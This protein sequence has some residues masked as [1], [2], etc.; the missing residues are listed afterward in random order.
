M[1]KW[2]NRIGF[3]CVC[4]MLCYI[5]YMPQGPS[6]RIVVEI[7]PLQKRAL[8]SALSSEGLTFKQWLQGNIDQYLD[9][10]SQPHFSGTIL[11]EAH[12]TASV[13]ATNHPHRVKPR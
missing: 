6:G 10:Q 13:T 1:K 2:V 3:P 8:Y 9:H 7:D 12:V 5:G 4:R 11:D